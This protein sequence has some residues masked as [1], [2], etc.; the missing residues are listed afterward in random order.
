MILSI[1][2]IDLLK[3]KPINFNPINLV[4]IVIS[5][6]KNQTNIDIGGYG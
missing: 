3:M 1:Y 6:K 4:S 2:L 5:T